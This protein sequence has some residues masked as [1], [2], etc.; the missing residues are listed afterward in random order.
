MPHY[1]L[2]LFGEEIYVLSS[3][4]APRT[5][6][7]HVFTFISLLFN[8]CIFIINTGGVC[9]HWNI[10]DD[11]DDDESNDEEEK[12]KEEE[13]NENQQDDSEKPENQKNQKVP[14]SRRSKLTPIMQ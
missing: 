9:L 7:I 11:D 2:T 6:S 13:E 14:G 3:L 1:C 8:I 4:P 12:E 5:S 10:L